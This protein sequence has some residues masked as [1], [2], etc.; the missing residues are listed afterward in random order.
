MAVT[1]QRAP[2]L[3]SEKRE[4]KE[5]DLFFSE[6]PPFHSFSRCNSRRSGDQH[7]SP[8]RADADL[9]RPCGGASLLDL[10]WFV[11]ALHGGTLWGWIHF[12]GCWPVVPNAWSFVNPACARCLVANRPCPP[13]TFSSRRVTR[14]F[15]N[16]N[17]LFWSMNAVNLL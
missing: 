12:G 4:A 14:D 8:T 3:G 1:G 7:Y 13:L 11:V 2:I 15:Q 16:I 9:P 6:R 5:G 17:W 10:A